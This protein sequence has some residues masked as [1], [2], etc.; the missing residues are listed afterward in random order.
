MQLDGIGDDPQ[1]ALRCVQLELDRLG[2]VRPRSLDDR[3]GEL[4]RVAALDGDGK[5]IGVQ[6]AGDEEVVDDRA[7]P[8]RFRRD[9]AEEL[10]LDLGVELDVRAAE[11][12]RRAVDRGERRPQLVRDRRDEFRLDLL[13]RALLGQVPERVDRP[14]L[15]ADPGAGDP[16][17]SAVE[18]DRH[19]LGVHQLARLARDGDPRRDLVPA[20][21]DVRDRLAEHI[22]FRQAG[23]RRGR[24]VPEANDPLAVDEDDAV[25]NGFERPGRAAAPLGFRVEARVVDRGRRV[26]G[27][28][29]WRARDR[30]RRTSAP[31]RLSRS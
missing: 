26:A 23:D 14:F 24:G 25:A 27:E 11:R 10:D 15:E 3:A 28:L 2:Q 9:H 6:A 18:L 30:S 5:L 29:L 12:L 13:E 22:G 8:V 16:E 31:T 21:D 7:E 1:Q 17:L 4:S 19:G 20:F